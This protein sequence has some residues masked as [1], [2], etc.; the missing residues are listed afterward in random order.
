MAAGSTY[1]P[2]QTYTLGSSQTTITFSSIASTYTD[3]VIVM[4]HKVTGAATA[5]D[6]FMRFN[7]D[8]GTNYSIT[9]LY[10]DNSSGRQSTQGQIMWA[11]DSTTEFA[12]TEFHVMNYANTSVNKTVLI[13]QGV[14]T[15]PVR[16]AA[17]WRSTAAIN[18]ISLTA[19]DQLGSGTADQFTTG[20]TFTLYGIAAA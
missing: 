9:Y 10:G 13:K 20:S 8:S 16:A 14:S 19:S 18:T 6:G 17:L 4:Q 12:I 15:L 7:S 1:T 3:L 5:A 2:I 11:I